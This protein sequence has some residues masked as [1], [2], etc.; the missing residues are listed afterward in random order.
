MV[1]EHNLTEGKI[2]IT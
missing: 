1:K 2:H